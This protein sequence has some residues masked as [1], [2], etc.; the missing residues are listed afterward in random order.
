MTSASTVATEDRGLEG[1]GDWELTFSSCDIFR[2]YH[3][4][5]TV[6]AQVLKGLERKGT[7]RIIR[8]PQPLL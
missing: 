4:P 1:K 6:F 2:D 3:H 7:R 5:G 8:D